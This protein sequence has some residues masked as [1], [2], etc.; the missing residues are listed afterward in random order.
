M[1][2]GDGENPDPKLFPL[3]SKC[4]LQVWLW[5]VEQDSEHVPFR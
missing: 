5:Q 2:K 3:P 1:E 4:V